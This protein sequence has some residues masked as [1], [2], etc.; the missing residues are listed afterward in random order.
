MSSSNSRRADETVDTSTER[1]HTS[2]I[3]KRCSLHFLLK[4]SWPSISTETTFDCRNYLQEFQEDPKKE[5]RYSGSLHGTEV[6]PRRE[7]FEDLQTVPPFFLSLLSL[8]F[9]HSR[10][11]YIYSANNQIYISAA[12]IG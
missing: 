3:H 4:V 12:G 1:S 8:S 2:K 6:S 11:K 9:W 7:C 10:D 5:K